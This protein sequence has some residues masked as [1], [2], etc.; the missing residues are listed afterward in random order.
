MIVKPLEKSFMS[1]KQININELKTLLK[2]SEYEDLL[3]KKLDLNDDLLEV[4][5]LKELLDD[6]I[7]FE[8]NLIKTNENYKLADTN[9]IE[10]EEYSENK[11][12]ECIISITQDKKVN[13]LKTHY[14]SKFEYIDL[15]HL[16]SLYIACAEKN[17]Y[18]DETNQKLKDNFFDVYLKNKD[19][20]GEIIS[21]KYQII[22]PKTSS[23]TYLRGIRSKRY[24]NYTNKLAIFFTMYFFY[25]LEKKVQVKNIKLTDSQLKLV[26]SEV[27]PTS[28]NSSDGK[29]YKVYKSYEIR[30]NEIGKGAFSISQLFLF[31]F[32][33]DDII[34]NPNTPSKAKYEVLNCNHTL[35]LKTLL[36]RLNKS[37]ANTKLYEDDLI[38]MVD[39][40]YTKKITKQFLDRLIRKFAKNRELNNHT[41]EY[42]KIK[43]VISDLKTT[44]TIVQG[45][46][47]LNEIKMEFGLKE[48]VNYLFYSAMK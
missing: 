16:K 14:E 19:L 48:Y 40:L 33:G 6:V 17:N 41:T 24:K 39:Q 5:G 42:T 26:L 35:T 23:V 27:N 20:L 2:E 36:K 34:I 3:L 28:I 12:K 30:N 37:K 22:K 4:L 45:L 15:V 46:G 11:I 10:F 25:R 21:K 29:T 18:D 31:N 13:E 47:K 43:K 32:N 7:K 8:K 9:F 1:D 38:S 44:L